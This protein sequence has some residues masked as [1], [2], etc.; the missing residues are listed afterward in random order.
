MAA[1]P[2]VIHGLLMTAT[3]ECFEDANIPFTNVFL[4]G[5]MK[6]MH[7]GST[8]GTQ[9]WGWIWKLH[10]INLVQCFLCP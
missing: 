3:T 1:F 8:S 9:M 2:T 5:S 7:P 10:M 4:S 6:G